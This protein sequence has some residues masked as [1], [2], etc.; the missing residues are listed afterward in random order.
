MIIIQILF[1]VHLPQKLIFRIYSKPEEIEKL[2]YPKLFGN[3]S[4]LKS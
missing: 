4:L 1:Y 3:Y 2:K